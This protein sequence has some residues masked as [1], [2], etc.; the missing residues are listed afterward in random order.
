MRVLRLLKKARQKAGLKQG[1]VAER[2]G[3]TQSYISKIEAGKRRL[4]ILQFNKIIKLYR[5]PISFFIK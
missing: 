5:K 1:E 3:K 2:I 4:D